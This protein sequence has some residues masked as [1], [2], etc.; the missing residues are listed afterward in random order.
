MNFI[1]KREDEVSYDIPLPLP[2]HGR[3]LT[4]PKPRCN[5][6]HY[7]NQNSQGA[8]ICQTKGFPGWFDESIDNISSVY[9]DR[10]RGWSDGRS[11]AVDK[12]IGIGDQGWATK[13]PLLGDDKLKEIAQVAFELQEQPTHVQVIHYYN[14]ASGYSCPV[15]IAIYPKTEQEKI[16]FLESQF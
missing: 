13:L 12:I 9:S 11:E 4:E 14:D 3:E 16:D 2:L 8:L 7:S 1:D 5:Y 6:Y 10:L 15:I